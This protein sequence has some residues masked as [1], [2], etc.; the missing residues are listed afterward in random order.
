MR[1]RRDRETQG[2]EGGSGRNKDGE[3][4]EEAQRGEDRD[5]ERG[6]GDRDRRAATPRSVW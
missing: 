2:T 5:Q 1:E 6:E 4:N 3:R